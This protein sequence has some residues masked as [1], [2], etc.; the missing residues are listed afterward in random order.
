MSEKEE[1]CRCGL[2]VWKHEVDYDTAIHFIDK[3]DHSWALEALKTLRKTFDEVEHA[4]QIRVPEA[5]EKVDDAKWNIERGNWMD[6]KWDLLAASAH[7]LDEVK[8]C[9]G[10]T[11]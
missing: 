9:A 1:K 10:V 5:K 11:K 4:C 3:R 8:K 7:L 6:A 2:A